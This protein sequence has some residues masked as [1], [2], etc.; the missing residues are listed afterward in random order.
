MRT[1]RTMRTTN[2]PPRRSEI[3][4]KLATALFLMLLAASPV[5]ADDRLELGVA[6]HAFDHLGA[7]GDQAPAAAAAGCN[8]IYTTGVGSL[9]YAGLPAQTQLEKTSRDASA[10][11]ADA[12]KRGIKVAIG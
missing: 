3:M 4:I 5:R 11:L 2:P 1:R 9:G 8:I 6:N 12:K 7:I 10:Y